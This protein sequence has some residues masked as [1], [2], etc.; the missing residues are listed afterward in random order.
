MAFHFAPASVLWQARGSGLLPAPT[1]F[2]IRLPVILPGH[3]H[4]EFPRHHRMLKMVDQA[5]SR[6]GPRFRQKDRSPR[7]RRGNGVV[8]HMAFVIEVDTLQRLSGPFLKDVQQIAV[9]TVE[10]LRSRA[11]RDGAMPRQ[12]MALEFLHERVGSRDLRRRTPRPSLPAMC[13]E[14]N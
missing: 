5:K 4:L 12:H 13:P 1:P 3:L 6:T 2:Q 8:N 11:S 7:I 14:E 9:L 10:G